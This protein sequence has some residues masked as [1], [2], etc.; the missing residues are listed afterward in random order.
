MSR[1]LLTS[2]TQ[3]GNDIYRWF[4]KK[5]TIFDTLFFLPTVSNYMITGCTSG[6]GILILYPTVC[7]N[8]KRN[9][10]SPYTHLF[11]YLFTSIHMYLFLSARGAIPLSKVKFVTHQATS[12][13]ELS[14][15]TTFA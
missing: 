9:C 14:D 11:T 7:T 3:F 2:Q 13:P 1:G 10:T 4:I 12:N 6:L 5:Y 8:W 15:Q